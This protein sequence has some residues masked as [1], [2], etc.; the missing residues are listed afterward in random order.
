[1]TRTIALARGLLGLAAFGLAAGVATVGLLRSSLPSEDGVSVVPGLGAAVEIEFDAYHVPR[2]RA[3]GRRDAYVALGYATARDRLFQMDLNR[4]GASGRLA[5]IFGTRA[6]EADIHYRTL[7]LENLASRVIER[8]PFEQ[9]DLLAA[10]SEGVNRAASETKVL[11]IEFLMLGYR[12]EHWRP[13]DCVLVLLGL[14][15]Q[16]SN[17]SAQEFVATVMRRAL[18][19]KVV[20]F[21]TPDGNC[22][23]EMLAPGQQALCTVSDASAPF[24]ELAE[25]LREGDRRSTSS[26]VV[27]PA[28]ARGSNAW[29]VGARKS[30]DGRAIMANDMHLDLSAPGVWY[31]AELQ[32]GSVR[33]R[34]LTVPGVP[35]VVSGSNGRVAWGLTSVEGDFTDLVRIEPAADPMRYRTAQGE[36]D[37]V[38]RTERIAVRGGPAHEL[39]VRETIWGP[40][41]SE[42][43][44]GDEVA[45]HWTGLDPEAT[46][47]DLVDMDRV[48]GVHDAL[49]VFQHAGGPPLNVLLADDAGKIAW[50]IMGR[51]PRRF[52]MDGLYSESWAEGNRGWTG[53]YAA[54]ETPRIIDPQSGFLVNTN[55]R[56]LG[57]AEFQPRIGH[58]YSGGFR[59]WRVTE[60]LRGSKELSEPA[61]L[62]LQLDTTSQ[63]YRYYQG[64]A[65]RVLDEP[66]GVDAELS[67]VRAY[68][69]AWDGRAEID[70]LGFPLIVEFRN[71]L[72]D[73]VI[74]PIVARCAEID[75]NFKYAWSG[76]DVPVQRIVD[77]GR[78]DLIP[79]RSLHHDWSS[80]L[81]ATL[82]SSL[83]RLKERHGGGSIERLAWGAESR[84]EV[85]NV[86]LGR[87]P[88]IGSLF[89]MPADPL[90]GCVECVRFSYG[91]AGAS[92]RMVVSPGH[93][94]D[95]YLELPAGQSG[96]FG[97]PHYADQEAGW[98]AG[99]PAPFLAGKALHKSILVPANDHGR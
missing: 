89:N 50:T 84:V 67:V 5:E 10:Y 35:L 69:E 90:P 63:F 65:L 51:L 54:A 78:E 32:Y 21:L 27:T 48:G 85:G 87:A 6:L 70:S 58:D 22:Y 62:S 14:S 86:V 13:E 83:R 2:I 12:P 59:A 8:L 41:S 96:Q 18:P 28:S 81:R 11:P 52:G 46:N 80:F 45:I 20:E 39:A 42:N 33:L 17:R 57:A 43:L 26:L 30:R 4:R 97:S 29:V 23:N 34:G 95:G 7:G 76:V 92:A 44:L 15:E 3:E 77:S 94:A 99:L 93:E 16:L 36:R 75:P 64:L 56:M 60:W 73:A 91:N 66:N 79:R 31:R 72:I 37:F 61:M 19:G 68:L 98:V 82:Q 88:I 25:L 1:M 74:S 40:L 53:Y 9:R 47:L 71:A 24:E 55:N 38:V 49:P